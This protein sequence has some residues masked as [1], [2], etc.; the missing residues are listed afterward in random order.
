MGNIFRAYDVRGIYPEEINADI[1]E[2]IVA[3]ALRDF[4]GAGRIAVGHDTRIGSSELYEKAIEAA[5]S[6]GREVIKLGLITTPMLTFV[7]NEE[8]AAGGFMITASHNPR[9][10]NGIKI[11]GRMGMPVSGVDIR[12]SIERQ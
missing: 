10:Y 11:V 12:K 3:A 4:I 8:N 6:R 5:E 2:K 9:E 7:V 1:V